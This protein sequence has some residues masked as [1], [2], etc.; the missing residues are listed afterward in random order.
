[1]RQ[2]SNAVIAVAEELRRVYGEGPTGVSALDGVSARFSE[3]EFTAIMGPSGSGKSTF[4]H[5]L[6]GL[7]VATSGRAW[8]AGTELGALNDT[9]LTRLR[10]E[11]VGFVFQSFNLLPTLSAWENIV[12]PLT[13]AGRKPDDEWARQVVEAVG[14]AD[15]LKHR[16]AQLSGGQQQRVACARALVCRPAI[17]FA[18]EPTGNLDAQASADILSFLR[19][20]ARRWGQTVVMVTHDPVAAGY[21]D[22]VLFL[23]DGRLVAELAEPTPDRVLDRMRGL[24]A[25][26]AV[27]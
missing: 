10:R 21:A 16:P 2:Q 7:D 12:L 1:M 6:A 11:R 4:L 25:R 27:R 22:R 20:S 5:C 13:L 23:A 24:D 26:S 15:R 3:G 9:R 19:L 8:I 18:D 17:V 14:L